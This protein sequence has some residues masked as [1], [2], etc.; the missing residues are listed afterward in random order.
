MLK[1]KVPNGDSRKLATITRPEVK[2]NLP[3][4]K[5]TL[6]VFNKSKT[7]TVE[8]TSTATE[9]YTIIT[10]D[11]PPEKEFRLS[12]LSDDLLTHLREKE[13]WDIEGNCFYCG[14]AD[15]DDFPPSHK[16]NCLWIRINE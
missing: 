14:Q 6:L 9:D 11:D 12:L 2:V 15:G 5:V 4:E 1:I 16:P 13:P 8:I 7:A 3:A 10:V